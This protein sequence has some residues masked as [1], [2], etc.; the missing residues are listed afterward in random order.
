VNALE[1]AKRH[2]IKAE[3]T[4]DIDTK[5]TELIVAYAA[6][7]QAAALERIADALEHPNRIYAPDPQDYYRED[8]Y[9]KAAEKFDFNRFS[10]P[11]ESMGEYKAR[12]AA[13]PY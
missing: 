4:P 8:E 5:W 2:M 7:A 1:Q 9:L 13:E 6:I 3:E 11:G 12:I 10:R